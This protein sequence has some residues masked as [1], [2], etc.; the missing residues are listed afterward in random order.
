MRL[1]DE[2]R[3]FAARRRGVAVP[4]QQAVPEHAAPDRPT[5]WPAFRTVLNGSE[6]DI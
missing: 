2:G 4:V 6:Q 3:S 1:I 5:G